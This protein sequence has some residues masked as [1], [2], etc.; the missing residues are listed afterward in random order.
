[1]D[2]ILVSKISVRIYNVFP[3]VSKF[4][5]TPVSFP[6]IFE[7]I[8][9]NNRNSSHKLVYKMIVFSFHIRIPLFGYI[10]YKS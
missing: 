9:I 3:V 6:N 1:M 8:V 7:F 4:M 2:Q 5:V 10:I